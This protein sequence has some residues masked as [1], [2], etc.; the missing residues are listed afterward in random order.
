LKVLGKNLRNRSPISDRTKTFIRTLDAVR[1]EAIRRGL[2][3]E[4]HLDGLDAQR[5]VLPGWRTSVVALL[6]TLGFE[7]ALKHRRELAKDLGFTGSLEA[8]S[9]LGI[10]LHGEVMTQLKQ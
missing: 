1:A 4:H 9:T 2:D 10:W 7:S 5:G 3:I 8:S 6:E